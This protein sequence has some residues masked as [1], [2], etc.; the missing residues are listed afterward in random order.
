[1]SP[2]RRNDGRAFEKMIEAVCAQY[3]AKNLL[4][5][6]HVDPPN[7]IFGGRVI[8][9][10]NPFLDFIGCWTE[11]AGR[12]VVMETKS[13][14][15][16]RLPIMGKSGFTENQF[17]ALRH[18]SNAGAAAFVL[19]ECHGAV[20]FLHIGDFVNALDEG[21]K[22]VTLGDGQPVPAGT[23]FVTHDFLNVMRRAWPCSP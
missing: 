6:K 20:T 15:E 2:N 3:Q 9:M 18:W 4:R 8:H 1:M 5:L 10:A 7:R 17:T 11:R 23:G 12:L 19:W 21:R 13:T 16:P 14:L 22:S